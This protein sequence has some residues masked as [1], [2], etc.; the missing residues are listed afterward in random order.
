[1]FLGINFYCCVFI[2]TAGLRRKLVKIGGSSE[3]LKPPLGYGP[4]DEYEVSVECIVNLCNWLTKRWM[5]SSLRS[6]CICL[7][8]LANC[9]HVLL[10]VTL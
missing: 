8:Q 7:S 5:G 10:S 3:P 2:H 9:C 6:Y 4:D 1:M